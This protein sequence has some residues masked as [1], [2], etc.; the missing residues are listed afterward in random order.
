VIALLLSMLAARRAQALAVLLLSVFAT[1]AAVAGPVYLRAVDRAV[2][3]TE[4][5][6]SD[7]REQTLA[8]S[9]FVGEESG[10]DAERFDSI[11]PR[12]VDID[13]FDQVYSTQYA[14]LGL[15]PEL[16]E[17]S[18]LVFRGEVCPH[19]R[20]VAGR[21][22]AS[23][24]ET[25]LGEHTARRLGLAPGAAIT[26]QAARYDE[27][28]KRYVPDGEPSRLTVAGVYQP[29]DVDEL[30]WGR[31]A[32]FALG[33]PD[34]TREPI[35]V[36]RQTADRVDHRTDYRT[37]EAIPQ[38]GTLTVD[39]I[40]EVRA[41][42]DDMSE[43]LV[44]DGSMFASVNSDLEGLL[45]RIDQAQTLARR[46]VPVA[47]VPLVALCWFVIFL[48]VAYGA[49]GRRH[50]LGLVALRGASRPVR[51]WLTAGE[52]VLAI[53]LG[54]PIG[55]LAGTA[56]VWVVTEARFGIGAEFDTVAL[57]YAGVAL[58]GALAAA[59]LAQ[60][61]QLASP[62]ADLLR[63]VPARQGAWRSMAVEATVVVLAAVAVFQL[64]GFE[65]ELVGLSL[66]VPSLVAVAIALVAARLLMPLAGRL[67][68][69]ALRR[70]RLGPALGALQLARRPGS[71]RLFVLLTVAV[72]LLGFAAVAVDVA[73]RARSERAVVQT[74]AHR[75]LTV[76][77][78]EAGALLH[79]VREVDPDGRYAMAAGVVTLD[80]G[81]PSLVVAD[82][83]RLAQV[84]VWR[85]EF[86]PTAGEATALLRPDTPEPHEVRTG[87]L[88]VDIDYEGANS[89]VGLNAVLRPLSGG[90]SIRAGFGMMTP[91]ARTYT[92]SAGGCAEGCRL[93]ALELAVFARSGSER[94]EI[95]VREVRDGASGQPILS[96]AD[97]TDADRWRSADDDTVRVEPDGLVLATSGTP[98]LYSWAFPADL[99]Y[100]LPVL[101]AGEL[102]NSGEL[103]GLDAERAEVR[104]VGEAAIL[105]RVG[106]HG[107]L[108]DLEYAERA[109]LG[110][111]RL[112]QP[113]VWLTA[114]A[115][116]DVVD[117]L[118]A[119]GLVVAGDTTAD[120][121]RASLDRR[122]PALAIWFHLLAAA[123]AVLLA[124]GGL[125]LMA[126]VDRRR[127]AEDMLALHRQGMPIG[128]VGQAALWSYL[129]VV[130]T[131][132]V[133]GALAAGV[134]WWLAGDYL[135]V[136]VDD[137]V[138]LPLPRWPAPLAV[139][140]PAALA[141]V[142]FIAA[143]IAVAVALR[144]SVVTSR[145]R[146]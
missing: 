142:G 16:G 53:L 40:D 47:A 137:S 89:A 133:T 136:F 67:G 43:D 112:E 66:L 15:E 49:T 85:P 104:V 24:G 75:V 57:P 26:V 90:A 69:R 100:P 3:Q 116:A 105:P 7:R 20:M 140:V 125:A 18:W 29:I 145:V 120:E 22:V 4:V 106:G 30:Y 84:A 131:A 122:S 98:Q 14:V 5:A 54:A 134:A 123:F 121:A 96:T 62:V 108:A 141:T 32:F 103:A 48:A 56:A 119:K 94:P 38:P 109:A 39:R 114:D 45:D 10:L 36:G 61:P 27:Q 52:S 138:Q 126:A 91:G 81:E 58:A 19:L 55:Y 129:P 99:P 13:G 97:L 51:W 33:A 144:R 64:R 72:A 110:G 73:G 8:M 143:A 86:G 42:L 124:V 17:I 101:P 50:E 23:A 11:G 146:D 78:V 117:R 6:D 31:S 102:P 63:R 21:C 132:L 79:A 70:G 65:G 71:H 76:L 130:M 118:A 87:S 83:T 59:L 35:F 28:A 82:T 37:V 46:V 92:A 1:G 74:G 128:T 95:L 2:V 68:A 77:P 44:G 9:T 12:M 34:A 60:R 127:R 107:V 41:D 88:A 115:P 111:T 80:D 135:P 139:G 113:Q 93:L 25:V